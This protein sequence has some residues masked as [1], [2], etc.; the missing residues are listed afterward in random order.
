MF[1]AACNFPSPPPPIETSSSLPT[2]GATLSASPVVTPE[3]EPPRLLTICTLAEPQSL[4]LYADDSQAARSVRQ[5]IYDGPLD[6]RGYTLQPVILLELP[7]LQN[8]G[9]RIEPV[10]VNPGSLIKDGMGNLANLGEGVS[11]FPAGCRQ[12][13]CAQAFT[14]NEAVTMDQLV[15]R[16]QLVPGLEWSDGHP[17]HASDSVYAFQ[18]ASDLYPGVRPELVQ[19]T[20]S[21]QA[22]DETTVE[23]RGLPGY[24]EAFYQDNFFTPLP[25]HAWGQHSA[26]DLFS[27]ELATR[28]PLG[29]GPYLVEEW[30]LGDHIT[31]AKNPRYF[32]APEGL[33]RFERLVFRFVSDAVAGLQALQAGECDLLD[34]MSWSGAPIQEL[35]ALQDQAALQLEFASGAAWEQIAFGVQPSDPARLNL[36]AS[37]E[38][39]QAV[40]MCLDRERIVTTLFGDRSQVL[41]SYLTSSHPLYASG[42]RQVGY[43]PQAAAALLDSLG[44]LDSDQ[45]PDTPRTALGV[46]GVPDDTPFEFTYLTLQDEDRTQVAQLVQAG[47]QAC[48]LRA[49]P[50]HVDSD[51]LFAPGPQGP[52][53]GRQF[54]LAQ[55]AWVASL[56]PPCGLYTSDEIPGP[57]PDYPKGWGGGNASGYSSAEFDQACWGA[58]AALSDQPEYAQ[59]HQQAQLI[60]SQ[61]LPALPL[62]TL[63]GLVAS[64]ADFCGLS[65]DSSSYSALSNLE[66]FDYGS[67]CP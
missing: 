8:G 28:K 3:P 55:F 61:D 17:L 57:Y 58:Q 45:D 13:G 2:V 18:L 6:V 43:D 24:S 23:W 11:Y 63:P 39:R 42:V 49:N 26:M 60:F 20:Q 27:S 16:F 33:P 51:E 14:G 21:Y 46:P 44:W 5:A 15:V 29:W 34:E 41:H 53:F 56:E 4:F 19:H 47:L 66:N 31:L 7:N 38:I 30:T 37:P 50:L 65:L 1:L 54:D 25:E 52:V 62:Y 67:A 36:F 22:L 64:R 59:A 9:A 40:A 35:L 32:R 48:G 10:Q 12:A